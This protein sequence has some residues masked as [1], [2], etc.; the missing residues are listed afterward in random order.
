MKKK[1][2]N[3]MNVALGATLGLLLPACHIQKSSA[4]KGSQPVTETEDP[5]PQIIEEDRRMI[6]LYGIPPEILRQREEQE[7][8]EQ[9]QQQDSTSVK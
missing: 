9:E 6:C 1:V 3:I 2:R 7:Q 8:R 4:Q 5:D